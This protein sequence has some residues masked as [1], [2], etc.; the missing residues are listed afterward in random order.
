MI[1]TFI[2]IEI[3]MF[4]PSIVITL[5]VTI[6]GLTLDILSDVIQ[7]EYIQTMAYLSRRS[8]CK[9]HGCWW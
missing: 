8:N 2:K 7:H 3:E 1:R 4:K 6:K 9:Q 5:N